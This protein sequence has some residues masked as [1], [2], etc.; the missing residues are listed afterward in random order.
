ML[1]KLVPVRSMTSEATTARTKASAAAEVK[2]CE[3]RIVNEGKGEEGRGVLGGWHG[4]AE[5]FIE[6]RVSTCHP[7]LIYAVLCSKPDHIQQ[8][9]AWTRLIT[10]ICGNHVFPALAPPM[11]PPAPCGPK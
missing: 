7:K 11:P 9:E 8:A 1:S 3:N 2:I 6:G 4:R 5:G 10:P